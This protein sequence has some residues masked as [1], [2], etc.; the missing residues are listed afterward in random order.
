MKPRIIPRINSSRLQPKSFVPP[1]L[2]CACDLRHSRHALIFIDSIFLVLRKAYPRDFH[3]VHDDLQSVSCVLL[4]FIICRPFVTADELGNQKVRLG[5]VWKVGGRVDLRYRLEAARN[6]GRL[7]QTVRQG[8]NAAF[9]FMAHQIGVDGIN[10]DLIA[11]VQFEKGAS[12][13]NAVL[14]V[15]E[16]GNGFFH[17]LD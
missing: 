12:E 3:V 6:V 2:L 13:T 1:C 4:S 10:V 11:I 9:G 15:G 17:A 5:D 14:A 8:S 16:S 7:D